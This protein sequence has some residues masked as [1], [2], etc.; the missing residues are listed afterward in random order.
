MGAVLMRHLDRCAERRSKNARP[1]GYG[2]QAM[3]RRSLRLW[4][5]LRRG[6]HSHARRGFRTVRQNA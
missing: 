4:L 2:S 6:V 5:P 3:A 1:A